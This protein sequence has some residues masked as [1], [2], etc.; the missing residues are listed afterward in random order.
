[1]EATQELTIIENALPTIQGGTQALS[2]NKTSLLNANNAVNALIAKIKA[3]GGKLNPELDK[4]CMELLVKVNKTVKAM[5]DRR[6][7]TT[8]LL[9]LIAT[10]FTT[11]ENQVDPKKPNTPASILQ[12]FRNTYAQELAAEEKRQREEAQRRAEKNQEQINLK[13]EAENRLNKYFF[14]Y[15][16]ITKA[17]LNEEFNATTLETYEGSKA[18]M[19]GM[20][21]TYPYT[22]F[23]QFKH[24]MYATRLHTIDEVNSL[25][26]MHIEGL[27]AGL[28]EIYKRD[29]SELQHILIDKFPSKKV[30]LQEIAAAGEKERIRLQ[31]E[32]RKREEEEKKRLQE[33]SV[34]KLDAVNQQV[35]TNKITDTTMNLFQQETEMQVKQVAPEAR[36]GYEITVTN[37]AGWMLIFQFWFTNEG[38]NLDVE[39]AGKKSLNQMK[40]FCEKYSHKHSTR[41][42]SPFITYTETHKAVNR[43]EK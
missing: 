4:E 26:H 34:L 25:V 22:H 23:Q 43:K 19:M 33:E 42:E 20:Q 6:S 3:N 8:Q 31:E 5:Y 13:A 12:Q 35:E 32:A 24:G 11:L 40:A 14:N 30:E 2:A 36:T 15:L 17:K 18:S 21:V 1:M 27:F 10:E 28:A 9:T 41:I 16:A 38:K 39:E 7:A 29:M 37:T